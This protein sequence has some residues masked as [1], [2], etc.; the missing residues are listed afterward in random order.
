MFDLQ[1]DEIFVKCGIWQR[2]ALPLIRLHGGEMNIS[3]YPL[4]VHHVTFFQLVR[5][6]NAIFAANCSGLFLEISQVDSGP[7][8]ISILGFAY[9]NYALQVSNLEFISDVGV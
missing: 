3:Q 5:K 1:S 2:H 6:M 9:C 7:L 4:R 8:P